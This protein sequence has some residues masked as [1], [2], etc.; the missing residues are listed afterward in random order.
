MNAVRRDE[1]ISPIEQNVIAGNLSAESGM[2][3]E[4]TVIRVE[5]LLYRTQKC[6]TKILQKMKLTIIT[7]HQNNLQNR[8]ERLNHLKKMIET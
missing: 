3:F 2:W 7:T 1:S 5:L 6:A 4:A 8:F